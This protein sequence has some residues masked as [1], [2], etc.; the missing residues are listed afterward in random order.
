MIDAAKPQTQNDLTP[1]VVN[2]L[3]NRPIDLAGNNEDY[4]DAGKSNAGNGADDRVRLR[5]EANRNAEEK[6]RM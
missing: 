2:L 1:Q 4:T 5:A 6:V 3:D